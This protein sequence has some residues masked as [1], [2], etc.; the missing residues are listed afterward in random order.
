V[1]SNCM[2]WRR[3]SLWVKNWAYRSLMAGSV[4]WWRV[5]MD[6]LGHLYVSG[7]AEKCS[8]Q[9]HSSKTSREKEKP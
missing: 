4:Y 8:V 7:C 6:Q 5:L 1:V 3:F 2:C 9:V